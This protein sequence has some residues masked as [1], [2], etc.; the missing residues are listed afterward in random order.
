[1]VTDRRAEFSDVLVQLRGDSWGEILEGVGAAVKWIRNAETGDPRT[2]ELTS[3]LVALANHDKWEIRR[4]VAQAASQITS[5]A[6]ETELVRLSSD[7]NARVR[8]AAQESS[9]R[10]RDGRHASLFG[11][12]HAERIN[13]SL[14][15]IQSRYGIPAREAVKR[16]AEVMANTFARE[17][18]HEVIKLI[19]PLATAAQ[20]LHRQ[21]AAPSPPSE[22]LMEEAIRIADQVRH[23][24]AVLNAMRS[25]TAV[26]VLQFT[27]ESLRDVCLQAA[28]LAQGGAGEESKP[29]IRIQV[30]SDC[31][32]EVARPRLV[33]AFT[34][35]LVNAVEAYEGIDGSVSQIEVRSEATESSAT[36]IIQDFGAGMSAEVLRDAPTFFATGKPNGTGFGLPLAIKIVESEHGGRLRLSSEKGAGTCVH[37]V[38]PVR[39]SEAV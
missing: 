4:A 21:L 7:P 5:P 22:T 17:L 26:P 20:R 3:D 8:Q 36:I 25:Y 6:F 38:V 18:Y 30:A 15:S 35:L 28:H 11:K 33:Q 32:C 37:V 16:T 29:G 14:D 2:E 31:I 9:L 34:N 12:E 10:R 19:S 24:E 13:A 39:H 27:R 1:M 23:L